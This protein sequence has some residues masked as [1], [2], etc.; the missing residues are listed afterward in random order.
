MKASGEVQTN[1]EARVCVHDLCLF[2]TVQLLEDT[3][4]V[5]SLGKLC[6]EH[7]Y[8]YEWA[9]GQM[10]HLAKIGKIFFCKTEN[11]VLLVDP[12]LSSSSSASSSSTSFPQDSPSTSSSPASLRSDEEESG[13]RRDLHKTQNKNKNKDYH[14]A[15]R[16]R[17]R[18]LP[19]W[20]EASTDNPEDT[21]VPTSADISHDTDSEHRM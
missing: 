15:A 10:P 14:E 3:F 8:S 16:N 17:L 12:R 18:D 7:G 9:S 20:L 21:E 19:K 1:E 13:N 2:V 4:A 5:K 11:F 6:E